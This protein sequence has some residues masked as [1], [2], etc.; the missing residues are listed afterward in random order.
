MKNIGIYMT[1]YLIDAVCVEHV[2]PAF[3]W[4]WN[5]SQPPIHEYF[6]Q[7]WEVNFKKYFYD[8]YDYFLAPLYKSI[9]WFH[10]HRISPGAIKYLKEVGYWYMKKYYT[11]VS[12]YGATRP[13]HLLPKYVPD[14]LLAREVAYQ[15]INKGF[16]AYLLEKNKMYWPNFLIHIG[17]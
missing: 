7:L 5:L 12:I 11:Y 13:P 8:I 16:I 4:A 1:T 6:Y 14:K 9:Y 10:P 15:P 3:N 17:Q 2:F